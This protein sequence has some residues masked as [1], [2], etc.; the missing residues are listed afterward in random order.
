MWSVDRQRM[1]CALRLC[2]SRSKEVI[3]IV[4]ALRLQ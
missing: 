4:V 1:R 2:G 3:Y